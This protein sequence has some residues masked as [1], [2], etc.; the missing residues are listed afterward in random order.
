MEYKNILTDWFVHNIEKGNY[1]PVEYYSSTCKDGSLLQ[2]WCGTVA[3][4]V[5]TELSIKFWE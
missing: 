1:T 4:V 3:F 5:D 2:A